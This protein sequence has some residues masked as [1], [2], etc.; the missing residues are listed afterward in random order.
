MS[1][2]SRKELILS[3]YLP[4]RGFA[5]VLFETPSTAVDWG[6]RE[7]RGSGKHENCI[8]AVGKLLEKYQPDIVIIEE[9]RVRGSTRTERI[10]RLYRSV[11]TTA[12][13]RSVKVI[14]CRRCDV[15]K[16]FERLGAKTKHQR[17]VI[18]AEH[19]PEFSY[20]VPPPR[21]P[22]TTE[23]PRMSLF[24]AGALVITLIT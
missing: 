16:C 14:S 24:E 10:R 3:I 20:K 21:K 13:K 9:W 12:R 8:E 18:V 1:K 15:V 5:F 22:W 6:T 19:I 2:R 23:H 4:A 11:E 7:L 17:A